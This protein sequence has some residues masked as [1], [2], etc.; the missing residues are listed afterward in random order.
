MVVVK[1]QLWID[2]VLLMMRQNQREVIR[3]DPDY[4]ELGV[5]GVVSGHVFQ[6]LQEF[7]AIWEQQSRGTWAYL[8]VLKTINRGKNRET[9]RE[10][11]QTW[12]FLLSKRNNMYSIHVVLLEIKKIF[13]GKDW[14]TSKISTNALM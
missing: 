1:T 9:N 5:V 11:A 4:A 2:I 12:I 6:D 7:I 8:Q 10:K 14:F 3:V 13:T